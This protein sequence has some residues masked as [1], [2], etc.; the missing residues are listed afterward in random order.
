MSKYGEPWRYDEK[1]GIV[2]VDGYTLKGWIRMLPQNAARII[3]CVNGCEGIKNPNSTVPRM[4]EA[5]KWAMN[6]IS[7]YLNHP[8]SVEDYRPPEC[9]AV[10]KDILL[11]IQQDEEGES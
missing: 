8:A 1:Q 6:V 10:L 2:D 4:E 11:N 7:A 9:L 3:A 5:C